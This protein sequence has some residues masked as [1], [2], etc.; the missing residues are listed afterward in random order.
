M[1]SLVEDLSGRCLTGTVMNSLIKIR[2]TLSKI[3]KIAPSMTSK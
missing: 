3:S 1:N 2:E